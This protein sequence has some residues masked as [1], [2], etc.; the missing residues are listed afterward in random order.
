M[1]CYSY[2]LKSIDFIQFIMSESLR[3]KPFYI[4]SQQLWM[5][6]VILNQLK[7]IDTK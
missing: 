6:V 1:T 4:H 5:V 3:N 2:Q 7:I